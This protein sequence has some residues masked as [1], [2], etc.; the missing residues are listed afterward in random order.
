MERGFRELGR[1][2]LAIAAVAGVFAVSDAR[3]RPDPAR[4]WQAAWEARQAQ[5]AERR[6]K[7]QVLPVVYEH[8]RAGAHERVRSQLEILDASRSSLTVPMGPVFV[9][10]EPRPELQRQDR[11][12]LEEAFRRATGLPLRIG[13]SLRAV[14]KWGNPNPAGNNAFGM[15]ASPH[16]SSTTDF[17]AASASPT[18]ESAHIVPLFP[19]AADALGRQGFVRVINHSDGAG[20]VTIGALF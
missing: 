17:A 12:G 2:M 6:R 14:P 18:S 8:G 4:S 7:V 1:Q 9:N 10:R 16:L 13:Y 5:E 19:S 3:D 11:Q 15:S 20:E